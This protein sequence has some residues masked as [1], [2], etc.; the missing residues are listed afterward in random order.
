M[1]GHFHRNGIDGYDNQFLNEHNGITYLA[2]RGSILGKNNGTEDN[3]TTDDSAY[4]VIELE[5][6][7]NTVEITITGYK[8]GSSDTSSVT[9]Q[10]YLVA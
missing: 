8:Q 2:L 7:G 4:W 3:G 6:T 1:S 5:D 10:K 9:K